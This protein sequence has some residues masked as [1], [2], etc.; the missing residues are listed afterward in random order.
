MTSGTPDSIFQKE[1]RVIE[2]QSMA[3]GERAGVQISRE[4]LRRLPDAS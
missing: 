1:I 4:S 3:T 2:V